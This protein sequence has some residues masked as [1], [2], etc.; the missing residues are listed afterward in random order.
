MT[1][2]PKRP[3]GELVLNLDR[4][5][6]P[7]KAADRR[8]GPF[9]YYGASGVVD[10]VDDY[11][12]EGLHLLVAEDGENLRSR[13]T[14]VAF[15]ASG[16]FWVNNHAHVLQGNNEN[17]TRYLSYALEATDIS[18]YITGSAQPKLNQASLAAIQVPAPSLREQRAIAATLGALDDKIESNRRQRALLRELGQCKYQAA[19]NGDHRLALLSEVSVSIARGVAPKYA[20]ADPE[21]PRVINQKCIRDGWVSLQPSRRMVDRVVK[22]EKRAS[23]GDILVN[24]TGT[25]TLGRVARWHIG[26]VFVDG[27]VSVVK[28]DPKIIPP[29]VLAYS[30]LGRESDIEDLATGSTGQTELS[31]SRLAELAVVIPTAGDLSDLEETLLSIENRCDQLAEEMQRLAALRDALLPEL[32]SGRMRAAEIETAQ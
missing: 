13:S 15:L 1:P 28:P 17:D 21:A 32:L 29:T 11:L 2:F 18:G 20:D 10:Y 26:D 9:P 5:R 30:L 19:I 16:R 22:V 31:P 6:I 14:A 23:S 27:H 4:K 25:G 3:I 12:F 24:S 8:V 7:V